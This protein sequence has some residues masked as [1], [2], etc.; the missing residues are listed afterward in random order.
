[1]I[2]PERGIALTQQCLHH[3]RILSSRFLFL[4]QLYLSHEVRLCLQQS[5]EPRTALPL[6][7]HADI[8]LRYPQNLTDMGNRSNAVKIFLPWL[9]RCD[10]S[11]G[12]QKNILIILHRRFQRFNGNIPFH[13]KMH[14]HI[15]KDCQSAQRQNRHIRI[16]FFHGQTTPPVWMYSLLRL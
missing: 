8:S 10:L 2:L 13:I 4:Q 7:H 5:F 1:M 3:Q 9:L 16:L 6:N 11:L 12:H 14:Q 15:G